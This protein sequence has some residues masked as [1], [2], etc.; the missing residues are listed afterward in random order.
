MFNLLPLGHVDGGRMLL[1]A[2]QRY[3]DEKKALRIWKVV[4]FAFLVLILVNLGFAFIY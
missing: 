3:F 4:S 2:L 1:V